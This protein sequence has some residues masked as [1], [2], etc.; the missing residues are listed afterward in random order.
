M[1]RTLTNTAHQALGEPLRVR[2]GLH[3]GEA[4][5]EGDDFFGRSVT[6]AARFGDRADG[7]EILT[8]SIVHELV[9]PTQEIAFQDAGEALLKGL[10][11]S[12][13]VYR[14]V[15]QQPETRAQLRAVS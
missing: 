7:S 6:L 3:T 4:I 14:G 5:R 10:S 2:I 11:G 15:W 1:Q 13:H 12:E 8:S 9:G